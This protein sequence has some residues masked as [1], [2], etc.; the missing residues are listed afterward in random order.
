MRTEFLPFSRPSITEDDIADV[1]EVLRSGWITTGPK[2]AEFERKFSEYVGCRGAVA[3][4]SATAGM[5]LALKALGIGPGDEVITPSMTWVSTVNLIVLSGA[6]PV[7]A[8]VE[9]DTLMITRSTIEKLLTD[10]TRLIVPVHFAGAPV[11]MEPIRQLANDASIA[12][13]E[14]AAHALG[15]EYLG[16]RIG[17][18]GTSVFSFHPIKNITTGEG[19]MFCSSD[20]ELLDRVRRLRFHGL[21]ADAYDRR[22]GGRCPRAEV[23]EP[24][25]KYNM[26]D[27]SAALGL[28]QLARVDKLNRKRAELA[29]RYEERFSEIDEVLPLSKPA[30]DS[31]HA[32]H[33][34]IVRLDTDKAGLSRDEFMHDL[35]ERNIGTGLHFQAV[36]LHRYYRES[37]GTG[38]GMLP[39]TEWNSERMCSLPLFPDMTIDDVDDV[40]EATKEILRR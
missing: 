3:L 28:G 9:P 34:Y 38:P 26:P 39:T 8:D 40:V 37:I 10:H 13:V 6:S 1:G 15:T 2:S 30:Y 35:K 21:G 27:I 36:H 5:H 14:D 12:I 23:L 25:Y 18:R 7:F 20:E 33:L 24:G 32:W 17:R 22:S 31:K 19:G 11:D 16:D 29:E 4:C